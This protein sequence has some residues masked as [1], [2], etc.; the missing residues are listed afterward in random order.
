MNNDSFVWKSSFVNQPVNLKAVRSVIS[1]IRSYSL[2]SVRT[3]CIFVD[4][5]H[6]QYFCRFILVL[7]SCC[8]DVTHSL[9]DGLMTSVCR[10]TKISSVKRELMVEC[11][12]AWQLYVLL[13]GYCIIEVFNNF[14]NSLDV[15]LITFFGTCKVFLIAAFLTASLS[16]R[17]VSFVRG[18]SI[19]MLV[20]LRYY[21]FKNAFIAAGSFFELRRRKCHS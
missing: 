5:S 10:S 6:F 4:C 3:M 8:D 7:P 12:T 17:Y 2:P 21:C 9:Q 11:C 1:M 15:M 19:W 18:N 14:A 13:N 20:A 16:A